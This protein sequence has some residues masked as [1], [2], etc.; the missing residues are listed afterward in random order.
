M[1][2]R[3]RGDLLT[4]SLHRVPLGEVEPQT[5]EPARRR[6]GVGVLEAGQEQPTA[7]VENPGAGSDESAHVVVVADRDDP[8]A[9]YHG[10]LGPRLAGVNRVDAASHE[11]GL[12][13]LLCCSHRRVAGT[14]ESTAASTLVYLTD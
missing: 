13:R 5:I 6:V 3:V 9:A 4:V 7:E 11:R 12:G 10:R 2:A 1:G 8:A 14:P